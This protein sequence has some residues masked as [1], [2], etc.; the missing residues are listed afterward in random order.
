MGGGRESRAGVGRIGWGSCL[1][2]ECCG[3]ALHGRSRWRR[4]RSDWG[5]GG[6]FQ[7]GASLPCR[8]LCW[9]APQTLPSVGPMLARDRSGG[10]L[11]LGEEV[12]GAAGDLACDGQGSAFAA[13]ALLACEVEGVVGTS[14]LAGVVGGFDEC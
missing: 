1:G 13:A 2:C 7:T 12:V 4:R 6:S 10:L 5:C 8:A 14:P 11:E 9:S 3:P